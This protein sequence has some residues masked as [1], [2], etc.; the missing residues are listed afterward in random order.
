VHTPLAVL[1]A[2][3]EPDRAQDVR[4]P[5]SIRAMTA[6]VSDPDRTDDVVLDR[7]RERLLRGAACRD[8]L[9]AA[10]SI[11]A[12]RA[13]SATARL[14]RFDAESSV[15]TLVVTMDLA[16]GTRV[17]PPAAA[18]DRPDSL[19][20]FPVTGADVGL[21]LR[22][23]V[24]LRSGAEFERVKS[25]AGGRSRLPGAGVERVIVV[26]VR[27]GD[28]LLGTFVLAAPPGPVDCHGLAAELSGLSEVAALALGARPEGAMPAPPRSSLE[29]LN[30]TLADQ[31]AARRRAEDLA[32]AHSAILTKSLSLLMAEP[33]VDRFLG[34]TLLAIVE[35]LGALG[36][37]VWLPVEGS[38]GF[39]LHL[40]CVDGRILSAAESG[41]PSGPRGA[42]S[43][44][45]RA[46]LT[47]A[48]IAT[49]PEI[50]RA[51][52]PHLSEDTRAYLER[53]GVVAL[54]RVPMRLGDT[55]LGWISIR[56]GTLRGETLDGRHDFAESVVGLAAL[57]VHLSNVSQRSGAAAVLEERARLVRE[58]HDTLAQQLTGLVVQLEAAGAAAVGAAP[59]DA[60]AHYDQAIML[61]RSSLREARRSIQA[62]GNDVV[63]A[64]SLSASLD[65]LVFCASNQP[66]LQVFASIADLSPPWSMGAQGELL[67]MA[68]EAVANSLRHAHAHTLTVTWE[69]TPAGW[70]LAIE[71]D[72]AGF[73]PASPSDGM[74]LSILT[75][76]AARLGASLTVDSRVGG[77]TRIR[78]LRP[79]ATGAAAAKPGGTADAE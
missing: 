57:A 71:D 60:A 78:V 20:Q 77:G 10:L 38:A 41:H 67:R 21:W 33:D 27:H 36:G 24:M 39:R 52:D 49:I 34:H 31:I 50:A 32:Q 59:R 58:M 75:D 70:A 18:G 25:H 23:A 28:R 68:Q 72:G 6:S 15:L 26:P 79:H 42:T 51:D 74:G 8:V 2:A 61:A 73:D 54:L 7:L 43:A 46:V 13:R 17:V 62:V 5:Q 44:T 53:L 56:H 1:G 16:G 14:Y 30:A 19:Y 12:A 29:A 40:E 37:S 47:E 35:G 22:H 63:D 69:P 48:Q 76:R 3:Q 55:I 66:G 11:A 64:D 65:A 45:R 4:D 9:R